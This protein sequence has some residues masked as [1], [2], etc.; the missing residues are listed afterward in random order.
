MH[1]EIVW[2]TKGEIRRDRS[3]DIVREEYFGFL[4]LGK[5]GGRKIKIVTIRRVSRFTTRWC[6]EIVLNYKAVLLPHGPGGIE[7]KLY[8]FLGGG[9]GTLARPRHNAHRSAIDFDPQILHSVWGFARDDYRHRCE[10][11][12]AEIVEAILGTNGEVRRRPGNVAH[13]DALALDPISGSEGNRAGSTTQR[14]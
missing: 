8:F 3:L 11:S 14:C 2:N 12:I 9:S 6:V 4:K 7:G 13:F 5:S 10:L 1:E